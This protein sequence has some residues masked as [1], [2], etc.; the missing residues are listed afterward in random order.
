MKNILM[1][2]AYFPPE[3][4][5]AT[6]RNLQFVRYIPKKDIHITVLTVDTKKREFTNN[7]L[8]DLIPPE[9]DVV[10]TRFFDALFQPAVSKLDNYEGQNIL[11]YMKSQLYRIW[12]QLCL[13]DL[14]LPWVFPALRK[15]FALHKKRYF[16]IIYVSGNP[17]SSFLTGALFSKIMHVPLVLDFQDPWALYHVNTPRGIK[18]TSVY[19][20]LNRKV[21]DWVQKIARYSLFTSKAMA[22]MY[23]DEKPF[24][25]EKIGFLESGYDPG[26]KPDRN[27]E[28]APGKFTIVHAGSLYGK[29]NPNN[30]FY[31]LKLFFEMNPGARYDCLFVNIGNL[32]ETINRCLPQQ[33]GIGQN[34]KFLER[35]NHEEC[36]KVIDGCTIALV[37]NA[38]GLENNIYIPT[39]IFD[40]LLLEK[41]T[42]FIGAPG[43]C[44]RIIEETNLGFS[45]SPTDIKDIANNI[46]KCYRK[47]FLHKM[48]HTVNKEHILQYSAV[49]K[50]K[51]LNKLIENLIENKKGVNYG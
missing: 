51:Q 12:R 19:R 18:R 33:L 46:D 7:D 4:T 23:I 37:V 41:P 1:I 49:N 14:Y 3:E 44:S 40:S 2:L 36:L 20:I 9:V 43:D 17:F 26:L 38:P 30:F 27:I 10:K 15:A 22:Q 21:E 6:F 47:Y 32:E 24:L 11:R 35:M 5:S 8:L 25:K 13:P 31:G 50:A 48:P 45:A 42:L 16:D 34:V 28:I 39:K 29:R